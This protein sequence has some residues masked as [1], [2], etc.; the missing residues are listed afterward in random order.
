[1]KITGFR[2]LCP[3]ILK[4]RFV[5]LPMVAYLIRKEF[6]EKVWKK[7]R[8][9]ENSPLSSAKRKTSPRSRY[10]FYF[11]HFILFSL[12]LPRCASSSFLIIFSF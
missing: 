8:G 6:K 5:R 9:G 2:L 10:R 12:P 1:M 7:V 11:L 4:Q 3:G